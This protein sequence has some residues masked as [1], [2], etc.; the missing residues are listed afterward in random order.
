VNDTKTPR[1]DAEATQSCDSG[2][3]SAYVVHVDFARELEREIARIT[4]ERDEARREVCAARKERDEATR[5]LY[6]MV[7]HLYGITPIDKNPKHDCG[8]DHRPDL[9]SCKFCENWTAAN[10]ILYGE[11]YAND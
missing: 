7:E 10:V 2:L 8:F 1:T 11:E 4:A 3:R 9:G 5:L 6:V